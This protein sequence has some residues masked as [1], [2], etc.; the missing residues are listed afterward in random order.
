LKRFKE[1]SD[2]KAKGTGGVAG[3]ALTQVPRPACGSDYVYFKHLLFKI[4]VPI[5]FP[6]DFTRVVDGPRKSHNG[7]W[8]EGVV[9]IGFIVMV[10]Q[11]LAEIGG[12]VE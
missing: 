2:S 8:S 1:H 4:N 10:N 7:G 6:Y 5:L 11:K 3:N 9:A 12:A